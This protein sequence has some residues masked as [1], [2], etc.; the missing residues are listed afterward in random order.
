MDAWGEAPDPPT[1]RLEPH[2]MVAEHNRGHISQ[3]D[4]VGPMIP[5]PLMNT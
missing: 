3:V 4:F 2:G 1:R 5:T